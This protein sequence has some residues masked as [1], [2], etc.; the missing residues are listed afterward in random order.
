MTAWKCAFRYLSPSVL[1]GQVRG[2][3]EPF[4][5]GTGLA[6]F[7]R[8]VNRN[9]RS[10]GPL[11]KFPIA[12]RDLGGCTID[13]KLTAHAPSVVLTK[14]T[15]T[16]LLSSGRSFRYPVVCEGDPF[17]L[18]YSLTGEQVLWIWLYEVNGDRLELRWSFDAGTQQ[19]KIPEQA[20]E[21]L[22]KKELW[23][24]VEGGRK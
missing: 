17:Y 12:V 5:A 10:L 2:L 9:G 4:Q 18:L 7:R 21:N 14:E 23:Y 8:N 1:P 15:R 6:A 3:N 16:A 22:N 13:S 19:R 20:V 11:R 24:K